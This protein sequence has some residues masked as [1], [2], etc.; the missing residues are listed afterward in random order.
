MALIIMAVGISGS[1]FAN[2]NNGG[3]DDEI[4]TNIK[5]VK[6]SEKIN[7]DGVLDEGIWNG[8]DQINGFWQYFPTDSSGAV[9]QTRVMMA[10]DDNFLYVAGVCESIGDNFVTNSLRRDYGFSGN[11]NITI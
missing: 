6:T 4:V 7:P 10:F 3:E 2:D 8:L 9:G 11:D 1:L 5:P